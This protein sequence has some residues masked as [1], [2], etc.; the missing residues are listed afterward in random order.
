MFYSQQMLAKRTGLGIVWLAATLGNRSTALKKITRRELD[1]INIT[2][3]WWVTV[4]Q[5]IHSLESRLIHLIPSRR[6]QRIR[7]L[8][9]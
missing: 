6:S 3:A 4:A 5:H 9:L 7:R 2:K 1:G 8:S